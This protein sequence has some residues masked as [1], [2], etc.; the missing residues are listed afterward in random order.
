[1]SP[2][3]CRR[4]ALLLLPRR[5]ADEQFGVAYEEHEC[6]AVA[7]GDSRDLSLGQRVRH[8]SEFVPPRVLTEPK[9]GDAAAQRRLEPRG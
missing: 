1:M 5:I 8:V 3:T 9:G 6:F 7:Q 4:A 2:K